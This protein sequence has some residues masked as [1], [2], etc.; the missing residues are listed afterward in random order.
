M[1][2]VFHQPPDSTHPVKITLDKDLHSRARESWEETLS[3]VQ[4]WWE[5]GYMFW[6]PQLF[7]SG[8]LRTDL[9]LVLFVLY[10][11]NWVLPEGKPI[12]LEAV[13]AN[14]GWDHA[15]TTLQETN[16]QE[17]HHWLEKEFPKEEVNNLTREC[18]C[19][20]AAEMANSNYKLLWEAVKDTNWCRELTIQKDTQARQLRH[21][22]EEHQRQ[23]DPALYSHN[24]WK[25]KE[26]AA[27]VA[28]AK[29]RDQEVMLPPAVPPHMPLSKKT[30]TTMMH[31]SSTP[32][33]PVGICHLEVMPLRTLMSSEGPGPLGTSSS[34]PSPT[35]VVDSLDS[36]DVTDP[37]AEYR[38]HNLPDKTPD[39]VD[40]EEPHDD[41]GTIAEMELEY[42]GVMSTWEDQCRGEYGNVPMY[43]A[44]QSLEGADVDDDGMLEGSMVE[45]LPE[46]EAALLQ[47]DDTTRGQSTGPV[48]ASKQQPGGT[49]DWR[50]A[51]AGAVPREA[52]YNWGLNDHDPWSKKI[53]L[54]EG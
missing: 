8:K 24:R 43:H 16:P 39:K 11:I 31:Q 36:I 40:M 27:V 18:L 52:K 42:Q 3:W 6:N 10:H 13:L 2:L 14:T 12:W 26:H 25:D 54:M 45:V 37:L 7:W 41:S 20:H 1:D 51:C 46:T 19:E 47:L 49:K 34:S 9:P 17:V 35:K 50:P 53:F 44:I 29:A 22:K 48:A 23:T 30:L 38:Q 5:A 28:K 15:R 32:S 33:V 21:F 4:Y